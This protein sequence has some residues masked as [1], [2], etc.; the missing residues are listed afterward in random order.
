M[1]AIKHKTT[2]KLFAGFTKTNKASW[3]INK[4]KAWTHES[5]YA[6]RAQASLLSHT[7]K[8]VQKKPVIL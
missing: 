8:G 3:T 5:I 7:D 6:A 2:G 4:S 1:F